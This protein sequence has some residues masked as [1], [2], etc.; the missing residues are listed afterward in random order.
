M[1]RSNSINRDQIIQALKTS[2]YDGVTGHFAY[3]PSGD[4]TDPVVTLYAYKN[5]TFAPL[6]VLHTKAN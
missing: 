5:G 1:R 4:I 6:Q 3:T 2:N